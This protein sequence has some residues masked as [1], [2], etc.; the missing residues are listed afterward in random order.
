M[1]AQFNVNFII[2]S[3]FCLW[4]ELIGIQFQEWTKSHESEPRQKKRSVC[5]RHPVAY[6][7]SSA[8]SLQSQS[9]LTEIRRKWGLK[10]LGIYEQSGEYRHSEKNKES[11]FPTPANLSV[12]STF[13]LI[14]VG[15]LITSA[16]RQLLYSVRLCV[17]TSNCSH[18]SNSLALPTFHAIHAEI[19]FCIHV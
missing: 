6:S 12:R 11:G 8:G 9:G 7:L 1:I 13:F 17:S 2:L 5:Y 4:F 15:C 10:S 3:Q 18:S 14:W 19:S 16:L